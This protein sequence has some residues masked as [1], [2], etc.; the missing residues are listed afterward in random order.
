MPKRIRKDE[1][2]CVGIGVSLTPADLSYLRSFEC[3]LSD[4]V[5]RIIVLAQQQQA[6]LR[7]LSVTKE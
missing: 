2:R 1:D 4:A 3:S 5:R 6:H 7:S